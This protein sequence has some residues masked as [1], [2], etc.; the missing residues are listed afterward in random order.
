MSRSRHLV[1]AE[2]RA[3]GLFDP[4][5]QLRPG[6]LLRTGAM[7][8]AE[9]WI[10]VLQ[11]AV[12]TVAV[13]PWLAESV[14]ESTTWRVNDA[15]ENAPD[16][17]WI[18]EGAPSPIGPV[19]PW[20]TLEGTGC[21]RDEHHAIVVLDKVAVERHHDA[22]ND[23]IV[24]GG[25]DTS[26]VDPPRNALGGEVLAPSGLWHIVENV[27]RQLTFDWEFQW[28]D[29][30][31]AR[32]EGVQIHP[33]AV[34]IDE[35]KIAFGTGVRV[36]PHTVVDASQGLVILDEGAL[37]EPFTRLEGPVYVGRH[38][39]LTGGKITGGC[40]IGPASKIGGEFEA[41]IVQGFSNK[42][43]E[44]FFGHGFIGEWVN[45]GALTTNSDLKNTYGTVRVVRNGAL[46]DTGAVKVG[47][48]ISDHTKTGIGVLLPTG[49]TIGAGT[50]I[51]TG[52]LTP[53]S[54]PPFVWGGQGHYE[55][56]DIDR[57]ITA[58]RIAVS[59]RS[60]ERHGQGLPGELTR[61]EEA[62]LR[63]FFAQSQAARTAF[64]SAT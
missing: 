58:A 10:A 26:P 24:N 15:I 57:M 32:P 17:L 51:I 42:V 50:N 14:Q 37:I 53:K 56:H 35:D 34:L 21:W 25:Q 2:G 8:I 9:R 33:S 3:V 7:T 48:Y 28:R 49:A 11:P 43:H 5:D 29:R 47:S 1:L 44:G 23:W 20:S 36:G 59:R 16:E 30:V 60:Y 19:E 55:D 41:S 31:G 22:L 52:G 12:I 13:R 46:V 27:R 38:T 6:Y 4:L 64:V 18:I 39:R 61:G 40:A 62:A 45:L 54:L 63:T